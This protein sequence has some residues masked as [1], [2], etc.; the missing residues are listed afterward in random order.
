NIFVD[1]HAEATAEKKAMQFHISGRV[2]ACVGTHTHI[3]TADAQIKKGTAYITD[4][5]MTGVTDSI[6]GLDEE[7]ILP[8]FKAYS[9]TRNLYKRGAP[10]LNG[11]ICEFD[12]KTGS[13]TKIH[14]ISEKM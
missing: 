9:F 6:L 12:P 11:A 8:R 14:G 2:T 1:F 10:Y 3:R 4:L 7:A 13:A 5:G